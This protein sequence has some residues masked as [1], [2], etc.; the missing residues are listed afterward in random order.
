MSIAIRQK[1][2]E[3]GTVVYREAWKAGTVEEY[4]EIVKVLYGAKMPFKTSFGFY[5]D[6]VE[7]TVVSIDAEKWYETSE[8]AKSVFDQLFALKVKFGQLHDLL[9]GEEAEGEE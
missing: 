8:E 7:Y 4:N 2:E 6:S 9:D 3:W 1:D 5:Y